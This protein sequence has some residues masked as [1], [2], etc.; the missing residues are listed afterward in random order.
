[1]PNSP[2]PLI[3]GFHYATVN[4]QIVGMLIERLTGRSLSEYMAQKLW[5][6]L[7]AEHDAFSLLDREGDDGVECAGGSV[8]VSLRDYGRLGL[9]MAYD[10]MWEGQRILPAGW[11]AEATIPDAPHVQPGM[12]YP[13]YPMGYQYQWWTF[14]GEDH[15][16][17]RQGIHGQFLLVNPVLDL[18]MVKTSDWPTSWIDEQ[19]KETYALFESLS[20]MVRS[21]AT[22]AWLN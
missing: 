7:G 16:F 15:A 19:E 8:N 11:V 13:D 22:E 12:L 6:P 10:G 18:V 1:M 21:R 17:N 9:L 4:T 5:Q 14:P 3:L 2:D 20:E